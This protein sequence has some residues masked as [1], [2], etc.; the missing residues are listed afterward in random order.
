MIQRPSKSAVLDQY[1]FNIY[2]QVVALRPYLTLCFEV[3][4][5]S[6][7]P[8]NNCNQ[9]GFISSLIRSEYVNRAFLITRQFEVPEFMSLIVEMGGTASPGLIVT[10]Q[11]ST[12]SKK[13]RVNHFWFFSDSQNWTFKTQISYKIIDLIQLFWYLSNIVVTFISK[14]H[15][16][17]LIRRLQNWSVK[18]WF[19]LVPGHMLLHKV[20]VISKSSYFNFD[21][22]IF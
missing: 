8:F 3:I 16:T 2:I 22:C 7:L 13:L 19:I 15:N 12:W 11:I 4:G 1:W 21:D 14:M 17:V 10:T 6:Y 9:S 5:F 20:H 18:P